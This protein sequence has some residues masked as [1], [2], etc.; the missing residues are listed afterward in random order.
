[1]IL[2]M[3]MGIITIPPFII[4]LTASKAVDIEFSEVVIESVKVVSF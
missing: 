3:A 4:R 2:K 1:M